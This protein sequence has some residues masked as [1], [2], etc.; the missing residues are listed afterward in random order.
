MT[1]LDDGFWLR[2]LPLLLGPFNLTAHKFGSAA[3]SS[4]RAADKK[5]IQDAL[6]SLFAD[7]G[8]GQTKV[9]SVSGVPP[10]PPP[11]VCWYG[12]FKDILR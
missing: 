4:C 12:R 10:P 11:A 1:I 8:E 2:H 7:L 3:R 6:S 5:I 9:L